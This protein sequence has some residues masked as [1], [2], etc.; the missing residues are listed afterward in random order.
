MVTP[1][2]KVE[3]GSTVYLAASHRELVG[4]LRDA[5]DLDDFSA[6]G[7]NLLAEVYEAGQW[8]DSINDAG[9]T[10]LRSIIRKKIPDL[11]VRDEAGLYALDRGHEGFVKFWSPWSL[12]EA[13][14]ALSS[15]ANS[16]SHVHSPRLPLPWRWRAVLCYLSTSV[17]SSPAQ[18]MTHKMD[19]VVCH[20]EGHH[21][22]AALRGAKSIPRV[23][24]RVYGERANPHLL[25]NHLFSKSILWALW[26]LQLYREECPEFIVRIIEVVDGTCTLAGSPG[27]GQLLD[28]ASVAKEWGRLVSGHGTV[29]VAGSADVVANVLDTLEVR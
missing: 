24:L 23:D 22:G 7:E 3:C 16:F 4:L 28:W 18:R 29:F 21:L 25:T 1:P 11:L 27:T 5:S 20:R 26:T 15:Y 12:L 17:L 9:P 2:V 14:D 8:W 13:G 19:A 6:M 10:A